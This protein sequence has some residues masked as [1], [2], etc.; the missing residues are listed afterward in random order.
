MSDIESWEIPVDRTERK[1][2]RVI[3]RKL[4]LP[5]SN[6]TVDFFKNTPEKNEKKILD[7]IKKNQQ[8]NT[9]VVVTAKDEEVSNYTQRYSVSSKEV[10]GV[11]LKENVLYKTY[12]KLQ[13]S[14]TTALVALYGNRYKNY[15]RDGRAYKRVTSIFERLKIAF[16]EGYT[17]ETIFDVDTLTYKEQRFI[18]YLVGNDYYG[19]D[20]DFFAPLTM[21]F[22]SMPAVTQ[23]DSP[24]ARSVDTNCVRKI[25]DN[26]FSEYPEYKKIPF[27]EEW[28]RNGMDYDD[29]EEY[30]K[31]VADKTKRYIN[32]KIHD[33]DEEKIK[34]I[35]GG[36]K[37][38]L[39]KDINIYQYNR[40]ADANK[41]DMD[42][43]LYDHMKKD[44]KGRWA[45]TPIYLDRI[46]LKTKI[47]ETE[48]S[49]GI[50]ANVAAKNIMDIYAFWTFDNIY[51]LDTNELNRSKDPYEFTAA[52][53]YYK[54]LKQKIACMPNDHLL[55]DHFCSMARKMPIGLLNEQDPDDII[56]KIDLNSAY[57]NFANGLNG[58]LCSMPY[59][60]IYYCDKEILY[61]PGLSGY[62]F[63]KNI[64]PPFII[65]NLEITKALFD[66]HDGLMTIPEAKWY[67]ENGGD[68]DIISMIP[69]R[70]INDELTP[71]LESF[72]KKDKLIVNKI[73][74][75][76]ISSNNTKID[77]TDDPAEEIYLLAKYTK[78]QRHPKTIVLDDFDSDFSKK[79]M[80][81]VSDN[82]EVLSAPKHT[83]IHNYV[84]AGV[85][86]QMFNKIKELH[87]NGYKIISVRID[88]I[89]FAGKRKPIIDEN[90]WKWENDDYSAKLVSYCEMNENTIVPE[91]KIK[92]H[93][94]L[95]HQL[96]SLEA[97]AGHGKTTW[98]Q[99]HLNKD[100]MTILCP[101]HTSVNMFTKAGFAA[102]TIDNFLA[103]VKSGKKGNIFIKTNIVIDETS[104]I[105]FSKIERLELEIKKWF[106]SS[107]PWA[108]RNVILSGD[109]CQLRPVGN[110]P[111][112][113]RSYLYKAYHKLTVADEFKINYRS[114]CTD[115]TELLD[116][117]RYAEQTN[118][119]D[120]FKVLLKDL[121][122]HPDVRKISKMEYNPEWTYL[123]CTNVVVNKINDK[124]I[125]II[126]TSKVKVYVKNSKK[127]R[128]FYNNQKCILDIDTG[129]I[130]NEYDDEINSDLIPFDFGYC[131]TVHKAQCQTIET[132]ICLIKNDM[133]S[134]PLL[135]TAL[136]RARSLKQIIIYTGS[137]D[138]L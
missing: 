27:K 78:E 80:L 58:K 125:D 135:Y 21:K 138:L 55:K 51:L 87:E 117:L 13:Q 105:Q 28:T 129:I 20:E 134:M 33:R 12:I 3:D 14:V 122:A 133:K 31:V 60:S 6:F 65:N 72:E 5:K 18:S 53:K 61:T 100:T 84:T 104:L 49:K 98:L 50:M 67:L 45:T 4:R 47:I 32:V 137:L 57:K 68:L 37:L 79:T 85:R 127:I 83:Y 102:T 23:I 30:T 39:Q 90:I 136:S 94:A 93:P 9:I 64:V 48:G 26:H 44:K 128:T 19:N 70:E 43:V 81:I 34:N 91:S 56:W 54:E 10:Q 112:I 97:P 77:V 25:F 109:P 118:N 111:N 1:F 36:K 126:D 7:Y 62:I 42:S 106:K 99:N 63:V 69:S 116:A 11:S 103:K 24:M 74:G 8:T 17:I 88:S 82:P 132:D 2:F 75:K 38:Y 89:T 40:H 41:F 92:F 86:I 123:T 59:E 114:K 46:S 113:Y 110:I 101:T 35:R 76:F 120:M 73:I 52:S 119:V 131:S 95:L 71:Y 66:A 15:I 22:G 121:T 16:D 29:I 124:I 115:F 108:G 107:L 130:K 96:I